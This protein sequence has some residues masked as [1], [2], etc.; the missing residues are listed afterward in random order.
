MLS[1]E[2]VL[3]EMIASS[4]A[5]A[6]VILISWLFLKALKSRDETI[7][8]IAKD[9][10]DSSKKT[11]ED[12]QGLKEVIGANSEVIKQATSELRRVERSV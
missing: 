2:K 5:L 10:S 8:D 4:P 1:M 7:R 3:L 9:F 12:M 6:G 11:A